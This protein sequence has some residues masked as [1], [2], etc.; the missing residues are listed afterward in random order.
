MF[1]STEERSG[2]ETKFSLTSQ[3]KI[4]SPWVLL[5]RPASALSVCIPGLLGCMGDAHFEMLSLILK[6]PSAKI[7]A[8]FLCV[9]ETKKPQAL[10]IGEE[11]TIRKMNYQIQFTACTCMFYFEVVSSR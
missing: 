9:T 8:Q 11:E 1:I 7:K 5:V 2:G 6:E 10:K 4:A 3:T